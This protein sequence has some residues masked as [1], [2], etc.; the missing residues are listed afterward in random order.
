MKSKK[1]SMKIIVIVPSGGTG[2]RYGSKIPKQY[3][4]LMGI[5]VIIRSLMIFDKI[6][7]ISHIIIPVDRKWQKFILKNLEINK[8]KKSISFVK[9][10]KERQDSVRNALKLEQVN[11]SDIILIHDAVR[12]LASPAL[13]RRIIISTKKYCAV[14]PGLKP[15]ESLKQ[16]NNKGFVERTINRDMISSI[17]TPQ[18]FQ[19]EIILKAYRN[20]N[21]KILVTD[22]ASLVEQIGV[23][24]KVVEGEE[25]NIKITSQLDMKIAETLFKKNSC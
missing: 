25:T 3:L 23:K 17:Q 5:P 1:N 7:E 9:G 13:V 22:D 24:V 2:K 21:P 20:I 16:I 4:E 8:L 11:D 10:G 15:K 12:P 18:G 14:I 6:K 19:T